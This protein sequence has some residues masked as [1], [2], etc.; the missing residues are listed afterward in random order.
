MTTS[1]PG[2]FPFL[3]LKKSRERGCE[4]NFPVALLVLFNPWVKSQSACLP[5]SENSLRVMLFSVGLAMAFVSEKE[6]SRKYP[7]IKPPLILM[8]TF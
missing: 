3:N 5:Y 1:F 4:N 8:A 6:V 7:L 2:L